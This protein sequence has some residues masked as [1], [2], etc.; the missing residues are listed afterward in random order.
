MIGKGQI[1]RKR[2]YWGENRLKSKIKSKHKYRLVFWMLADPVPMLLQVINGSSTLQL[3]MQNC[4]FFYGFSRF[5]VYGVAF[6]VMV[7]WGTWTVEML[8]G[9]FGC[10]WSV[11]SQLWSWRVAPWPQVWPIQMLT[12]TVVF[13]GT[14]TFCYSNGLDP[15]T[16]RLT[17]NQLYFG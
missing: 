5:V 7:F 6:L 17:Q 16:I 8:H 4:S 10:I 3:C 9:Q 1:A 11:V 12:R 13:R 15:K 2:P 14:K